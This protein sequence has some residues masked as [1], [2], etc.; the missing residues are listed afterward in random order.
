MR[1]KTSTNRHQHRSVSEVQTHNRNPTIRSDQ[2]GATSDEQSVVQAN[3]NGNA[4]SLPADLDAF[5]VTEPMFQPAP[6]GRAIAIARGRAVRVLHKILPPSQVA[7][8]VEKTRDK[9]S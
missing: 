3:E 9:Q 8:Y 7:D 4:G 2:L 6:D 5:V 1:W